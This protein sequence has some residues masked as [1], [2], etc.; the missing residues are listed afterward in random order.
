MSSSQSSSQRTN[1]TNNEIT[2]TP[3]DP[4]RGI[5]LATITRTR[6]GHIEQYR[7][8]HFQDDRV[9]PAAMVATMSRRQETEGRE[10]DTSSECSESDDGEPQEQAKESCHCYRDTEIDDSS[11]V[12]NGDVVNG[13]KPS[14]A[15]KHY[16]R[17]GS[18]KGKS[19]LVN[20][21]LDKASFAA[22]F[23]Q[24]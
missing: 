20:G 12:F 22:F 11:H 24:N 13:M 19:K 8:F 6:S 2:Q 18:V 1:P 5:G 23:C 21:D 9:I 17:G 10:L 3:V 4:Q 14:I 15:R 7:R 16:M